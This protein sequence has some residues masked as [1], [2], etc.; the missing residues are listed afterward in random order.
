MK[1]NIDLD[2]VLHDFVEDAREEYRR[3]FTLYEDVTCLPEPEHWNIWEQWCSNAYDPDTHDLGCLTKSQF[4][5]LID[6]GISVG[7]VYGGGNNRLVLGAKEGLAALREAGHHIRIVTSK[8]I[9]DRKLRGQA[10]RNVTY[11][12]DATNLEYDEI[13]FVKGDKQDFD[14]DIVID[15][16]PDTGKWAQKGKL[17]ILFAQR[18]NEDY[19]TAPAVEMWSDDLWALPQIEVKRIVGWEN[20]VA[21][22]EKYDSFGPAF[23]EDELDGKFP[24]AEFSEAPDIAFGEDIQAVRMDI[25][26]QA[27]DAVYGPRQQDYGHPRRNF[28]QTADLWNAYFRANEQPLLFTAED[29]AAAMILVKMSR[30]SNSV[31]ID[32]LVDL[33]GYA[34][35]WERVLT[36][37]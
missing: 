9:T 11:F 22:V 30:L 18:W 21:E 13:C 36:G 7:R 25:L 2:G 37:E 1:I 8:A 20:V 35:T 31:T 26:Q 19:T 27:R 29:I 24:D 4:W 32:S 17:N 12:L 3:A 14:A 34:A 28:Q 6:K 15:D 33:A 16:K 5:T 10:I 23:P